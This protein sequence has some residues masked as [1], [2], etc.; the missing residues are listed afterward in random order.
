LSALSR[1]KS[2]SNCFSKSDKSELRRENEEFEIF[3]KFVSVMRVEDDIAVD[4]ENE[5][6]RFEKSIDSKIEMI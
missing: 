5:M 4:D 3:V 1:S 6:I 2:L